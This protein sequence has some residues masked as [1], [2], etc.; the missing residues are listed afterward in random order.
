VTA[1]LTARGVSKRYARRGPWVLDRVDLV[2]A[3]GTTTLARVD[4]TGPR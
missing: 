1:V 2:A 4:R 3:P